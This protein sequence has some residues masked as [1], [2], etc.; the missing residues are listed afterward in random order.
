[1]TVS[2]GP[3][4]QSMIRFMNYWNWLKI[5]WHQNFFGLWFGSK[6]LTPQMD[7]WNT[8]G[9]CTL[10][11]VKEKKQMRL[12]PRPSHRLT[13]VVFEDDHQQPGG[14]LCDVM[15]GFSILFAVT[16]WHLVIC[17]KYRGMQSYP[18][19]IV[20]SFEEAIEL[21][22]P[23]NLNQTIEMEKL[24]SSVLSVGNVEN[25]IPGWKISWV[26]S[27]VT[28]CS[29]SAGS[30]ARHWYHVGEAQHLYQENWGHKKPGENTR[31]LKTTTARQRPWKF[32]AIP[33]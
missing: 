6:W 17:C 14:I 8:R 22:I 31:T 11:F 2:C 9:K 29:T 13:S 18:S 26:V 1:M 33:Q 10:Q 21:R 12:V 28:T 15:G 24:M 16:N 19:Y 30:R 25:L 27:I 20:F 3:E 23:G 7:T 4:D 32:W 5:L